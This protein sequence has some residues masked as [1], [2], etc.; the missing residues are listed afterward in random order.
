MGLIN[1]HYTN[2]GPDGDVPASGYLHISLLF[3]EVVGGVI[4]TTAPET[5]HLVDGAAAVELSTTGVNQA[6]KIEE[7]GGI[8]GR[9][10]VYVAVTGDAVFT[11][12][13]IVDPATL[14][15]LV[16][17]PPTVAELLDESKAILE[18]AIA[19]T[20]TATVDPADPDVI[21]LDYPSFML[22][23]NDNLILNLTLGASA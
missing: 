22:D 10:T 16:E 19:R 17:V 8:A 21:L 6:W 18:A 7:G 23:P 3:R 11:D 15:P 20:V 1:F 12:L 13:V 5:V 14:Q 2:P 9:R 4:R